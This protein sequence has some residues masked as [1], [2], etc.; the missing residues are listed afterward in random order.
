MMDAEEPTEL[1]AKIV[2]SVAYAVL[3]VVVFGSVWLYRI[4]ELN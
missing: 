2:R 4:V 1:E 3:A